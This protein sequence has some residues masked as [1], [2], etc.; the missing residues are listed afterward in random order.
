VPVAKGET[1]DAGRTRG[2]LLRAAAELFYR[3]GTSVG[4]EEIARRAAV[5]KLTIYRHFGSKEALLDEVLRQRSDQVIAWLQAAADRPDDPVERLLAVFDALHGWY[6]EA[7]FRGCAI[8]N[9]ATQVPAP[10]SPARRIAPNHLGR[11][12]DLLTMLA[13][14][15]GAQEPQ[16]AGRQLLI[17]LE[18]ATVVAALTGDADAATDARE[19]A[20]RVLPHHQ[21]QTQP[22][23]SDAN[24]D[25]A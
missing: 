11:L 15:A 13:A 1:I 25:P 9:A 22:R 6:T 14:D 24:A 5:S 10:S 3:D 18:G 16:L 7:R 21:P 19:L 12:R 2:K 8:V 17:L 20:R 23:T 4:V